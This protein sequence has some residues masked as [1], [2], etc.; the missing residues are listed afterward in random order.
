MQIFCT[1]VKIMKFYN[2][3]HTIKMTKIHT[4]KIEIL[5]KMRASHIYNIHMSNVHMYVHY[6]Y[7]VRTKN[8]CMSVFLHKELL[9][10]YRY[11]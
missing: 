7:I 9:Y 10:R 4:I 1:Y 11:Y 6:T 5:T 8:I 2:I 3:V